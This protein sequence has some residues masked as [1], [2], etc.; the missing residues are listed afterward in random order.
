MVV[1]LPDTIAVHSTTSGDNLW[2][3]ELECTDASHLSEL[4]ESL[5]PP[6]PIP[7][8]TKDIAGYFLQTQDAEGYKHSTMEVYETDTGEH[9]SSFELSLME[10]DNVHQ[11]KAIAKGCF[12]CFSFDLSVHVYM[13]KNSVVNTYEIPFPLEHFIKN[14]ELIRLKNSSQRVWIKLLGFLGKTNVLIGTL[15]TRTLSALISLDLDAAIAAKSDKETQLAFNLHVNNK[16]LGS[17]SN[18]FKP[19]YRTD[20]DTGCVELVGVM[21]EKLPESLGDEMFTID[22]G[23]FVTQMQIPDDQ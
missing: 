6:A 15:K 1:V 11:G 2:K 9:I 10:F 3:R 18:E 20:R 16:P 19:V 7:F 8:I 4:P 14:K 12:I 13:V 23:F 21:R 22:T 5:K 17:L